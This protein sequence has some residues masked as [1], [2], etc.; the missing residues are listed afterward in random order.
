MTFR[1]YTPVELP[2]SKQSFSNEIV[3][4]GGKS[5]LL[6]AAPHFRWKPV[7]RGSSC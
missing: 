6:P 1:I 3:P 4:T 5:L 2:M 7:K